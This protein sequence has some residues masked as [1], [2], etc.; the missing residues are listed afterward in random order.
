M[1][2]QIAYL[3]SLCSPF[4][5]VFHVFF[6]SRKFMFANDC[7]ALL[8]QGMVPRQ[9][10]F[11]MKMIFLIALVSMRGNLTLKSAE[12]KD[13]HVR[14]HSCTHAVCRRHISL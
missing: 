3:I 11:A 7:L 6:N 13:E 12:E 10:K 9:A 5:C 8:L 2:S 1:S 4:V 14:T